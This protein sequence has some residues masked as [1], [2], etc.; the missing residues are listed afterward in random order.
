MLSYKEKKN[1]VVFLL[2]SEHKS[3]E[4]HEGEKRKPKAILD[5]NNNKGGVDSANEMFRS[6]STKASSR[7]WLLA[8]FFNVLDSVSPDTYIIQGVP[9]ND[10]I[11]KCNNYVHSYSNSVKF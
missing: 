10:T 7:R 1:N 9:K 8:A 11:L 4:V 5:Y 6:Y 3:V 2:L